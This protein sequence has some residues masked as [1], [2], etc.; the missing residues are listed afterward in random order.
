MFAMVGG[1]KQFAEGRWAPESFAEVVLQMN[2]NT[3]PHTDSHI[4]TLQP[5][6]TKKSQY[7]DSRALDVV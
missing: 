1:G 4:I 2:S 7:N 3:P 6:V 5:W